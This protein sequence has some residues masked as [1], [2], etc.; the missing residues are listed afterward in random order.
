L[1]DVGCGSASIGIEWMLCHA[2]NRA[3]GIEARPGRAARAARNALSLGVPSLRVVLG[4]A[5]AAFAE[6]PAPDAV[7]VGGGAQDVG[8]LDEAWTALRPGGRMVAN[9][10]TIETEALLFAAQRARGGT[11]SRIS[12]DRLD[13]LGSMHGFRRAMTVTQW[14]ATKP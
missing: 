14:A 4:E 3:I 13:S 6:L 12:V 9:A 2:A 11:L 5:P 8:V 7:F 1:W 10:V